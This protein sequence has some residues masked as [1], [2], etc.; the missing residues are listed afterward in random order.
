MPR[1]GIGSFMIPGQME[2]LAG[3]R[4]TEHSLFRPAS[5][6]AGAESIPTG[7][8]QEIR[9]PWRYCADGSRNSEC[10]HDCNTRTSFFGYAGIIT[11]FNRNGFCLEAYSPAS[12]NIEIRFPAGGM[13]ALKHRT[14]TQG[15]TC[16]VIQSHF[17]A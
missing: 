1:T 8:C 2:L 9:T 5:T 12:Q 7:L 10:R 16:G 13:T 15:Q 11:R 4:L 14:G 3:I 17:I 6:H